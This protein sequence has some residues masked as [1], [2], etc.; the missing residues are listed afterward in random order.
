MNVLKISF[1]RY[2]CLKYVFCTLWMS[3]RCLLYVMN[4]LKTS[5]VR[6]ECLKDVLFYV[7]NVLKTSFVCCES[8]Y[9]TLWI[10]RRYLCTFVMKILRKCIIQ[11]SSWFVY[12]VS[13]LFFSFKNK[14]EKKKIFE[15]KSTKYRV[16]MILKKRYKQRWKHS[17]TVQLMGWW[18]FLYLYVQF[19]QKRKSISW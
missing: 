12:L 17:L 7:V 10:F 5:F 4:V 11:K 14:N 3:E 1:V 19:F 9:C 15:E 18:K 8:F 6:C 2:G 16:I 13:F